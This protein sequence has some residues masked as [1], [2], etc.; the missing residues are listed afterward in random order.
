M[1][2]AAQPLTPEEMAARV[3]S[4]PQPARDPVD[5]AVRLRGLDPSR[6]AERVL[7]PTPREGNEEIFYV[8]DQRSARLVETRATLRLVTD[9]SLW[10]V[11]TNLQHL[12]PLAD[13]RQAAEFFETVTYPR[14]VQ[15]FGAPPDP[16][17]D[18]DPRVVFFLGDVPMVAAYF[19]GAD[20][21]PRV[22][23]PRSNERDMIFVNLLGIRPGQAGFDA[24]MVH[25]LQH[26]VHFNRCPRQETWVDEG[27]AELASEIVGFR[28]GRF[29][30]FLA[31]PD[32]QVNAWTQEPADFMRHYEGS[33]LLVRYTMERLGGPAAL[34]SMYAGCNKGADFFNA[35]LAQ[36]NPLATFEDL[37]TDWAVANLVDDPSIE[38]GRYGYGDMDVAAA[39]ENQL[40]LGSSTGGTAPQYAATYVELPPGGGS[41]SFQG[42]P[43][44]RALATDPPSGAAYWWSN[45]ADSLN[46]RLTRAVDLRGVGSATLQF[47]AWYDIEQGFDYA[48]VSVSNDGGSTWRV[49]PGVT[50]QPDEQVGNNFGPG[51]TGLSG[52]SG[53][54]AWIDERVD[55]TPYAGQEILLRF[56]YLTDQGYNAQGFALD[57][58]SIPEIGWFDDAEWEGDWIAEGWIRVAGQLPQRWNVRHVRWTPSGT[59]VDYVPV[60]VSGG[61]T[62]TLDPAASRA[63][64]VLVPTAPLTLQPADYQLVSRR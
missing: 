12:A 22:L 54:P 40:P 46:T 7:R 62:V 36:V 16:G 52:G 6:L 14:V 29:R 20:A 57:D 47:R 24:T 39:V 48:Y 55:L 45:R 33:Y 37:V 31:R 38:D 51:F 5:L 42:A 61:A 59:F 49:L 19:S 64:L 43:T 30:S 28:T 23:N 44:V 18:G 1:P 41:V 8:L 27:S 32:V 21:Y 2:A 17:V 35:A 63:V 53:G 25:E 3:A 56:E 34:P 11:Q 50:A 4:A 13:L 15:S 10:Y 60:D 58:I 26:M 9:H